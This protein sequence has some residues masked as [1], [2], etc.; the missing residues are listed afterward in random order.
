MTT[1]EAL[2]KALEALIY[3]SSYCDT[4]DAITAIKQARALDKKA[5]NARELGLDYEPV[6]DCFWKREGYK[7]CPAAQP[8]PVRE[9]VWIQPDHLQKAQKAPFLCR[10]EPHKRDDFV[11]LYTT[12]PAQEFVC[13]TGLCHF[14]LTQTNVGIGERGMQ[15]YEA[16]KKRGWVGVSDERLM[17]M[18]EQSPAAQRS[19][20]GLTDEERNKLWR[21]VIKWGDPSHD[22]VDLIKAIE[23]KLKEKNT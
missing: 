20:V 16:A 21:D 7:E 4:Y 11:P 22:D 14:T 17:E 19:W 8:T 9:P 3:A 10:V 12:P 23:A 2:D 1:D 18:P 6:Q 13:S 5:E 15:A